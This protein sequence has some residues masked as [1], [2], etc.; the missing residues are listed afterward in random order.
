MQGAGSRHSAGGEHCPHPNR[1]TGQTSTLARVLDCVPRRRLDSPSSTPWSPRRSSS[2]HPNANATRTEQTPQ[3][4]LSTWDVWRGTPFAT[5]KTMRREGSSAV[6]ALR[7]RRAHPETQRHGVRTGRVI[8][9]KGSSR[10]RRIL[11]KKRSLRCSP[12]QADDVHGP[13]H[14]TATVLPAPGTATVLP[15]PGQPLSFL[16]REGLAFTC[17]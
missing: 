11:S 4:A 17:E 8:S 9:T 16:P 5:L 2:S 15:A 13:C 1:S 12:L 10:D 6:R 3:A 7:E 14:G